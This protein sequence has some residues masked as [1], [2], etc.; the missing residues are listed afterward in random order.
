MVSGVPTTASRVR[1]RSKSTAMPDAR[2]EVAA[3]R[4]GVA[5]PARATAALGRWS[6][7]GEATPGRA[8]TSADALSSSSRRYTGKETT[9]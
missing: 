2:L 6:P 3:S 1:S 9:K 4:S 7:P 5:A 8:A